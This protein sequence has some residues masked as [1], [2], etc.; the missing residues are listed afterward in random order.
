[1][2]SGILTPKPTFIIWKSG[3]SE[4]R[5]SSCTVCCKLDV[6]RT[7]AWQLRVKQ[8]LAFDACSLDR[9]PASVVNVRPPVGYHFTTRLLCTGMSIDVDDDRTF[10]K[11]V[12]LIIPVRAR[13][14]PDSI[15]FHNLTVRTASRCPE[16]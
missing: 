3:F 10:D 12:I 1:M 7:T 13:A 2:H 15:G 9:Q 11:L 4:S 8:R 6:P 14:Q 5:F 16:I